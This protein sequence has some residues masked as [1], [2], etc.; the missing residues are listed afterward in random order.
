[1]YA[2]GPAA[3]T[4]YA[5]ARALSIRTAHSDG[6][7]EA[8]GHRE[9]TTPAVD[10][11]ANDHHYQPTETSPP[12]PPPLTSFLGTKTTAAT[13]VDDTQVASTA[14]RTLQMQLSDSTQAT[15]FDS[16]VEDSQMQD[17]RADSGSASSYTATSRPNEEENVEEEGELQQ[18]EQTEVVAI[19]ICARRGSESADADAATTA[20]AACIVGAIRID[21]PAVLS[22]EEQHEHMTGRGAGT[23]P[24]SSWP[25]HGSSAT[26]SKFAADD[27]VAR[28]P[29]LT[30]QPQTVMASAIQPVAA[31]N[32]KQEQG[33]GQGQGQKPAAKTPGCVGVRAE[34]APETR[35]RRV[36]RI[37]QRLK[38]G[39]LGIVRTFVR[40]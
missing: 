8:R 31:P 18:Q 23:D 11:S 1:M 21:Q 13:A 17:S 12:P 32:Q 29:S 35:E 16:F 3:P 40:P 14:S 25:T 22:S 19:A 20:S 27:A 30:L 5:R 26:A 6:S 15:G 4:A 37:R 36:S 9:P 7:D 28:P 2:G 10:C 33:K 24:W 39:W 34:V 38:R